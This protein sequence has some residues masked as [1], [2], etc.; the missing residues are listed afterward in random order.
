MRVP[1]NPALLLSC[2][3]GVLVYKRWRVEMTEQHR[4]SF[5]LENQLSR[6]I[7]REPSL[8]YSAFAA[9]AAMALIVIVLLALTSAT[10][11]IFLSG[12]ESLS[13]LEAAAPSSMWS[14]PP[15]H[16]RTR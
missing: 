13:A 11:E 7:A 12:G 10:T 9:H 3:G 5:R 14:R 2:S 8:S 6:K 15:I 4:R 1:E 16:T